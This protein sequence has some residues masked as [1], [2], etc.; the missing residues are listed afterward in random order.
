[1][2]A[3]YGEKARFREF[4]PRRGLLQ[5]F[6]IGGGA[7]LAAETAAALEARL[8]WSRFGV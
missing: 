5:R 8:M 4:S 1:M 3:K 6:G 2:R 7:E